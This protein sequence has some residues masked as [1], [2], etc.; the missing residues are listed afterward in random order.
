M[1]RLGMVPGDETRCYKDLAAFAQEHRE[2]ETT[3]SRL[4]P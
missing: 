1:H 4:S 3:K 2:V